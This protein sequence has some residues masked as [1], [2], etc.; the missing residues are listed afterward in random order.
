LTVTE[1]YALTN[2]QV[3]L[4]ASGLREWASGTWAMQAAVEL[5]LAHDVWC[6]RPDFIRACMTN[7]WVREHEGDRNPPDVVEWLKRADVHVSQSTPIQIEW[8]NM[9][10]CCDLLSASTSER[11]IL[12]VAWAFAIGSL[13]NMCDLSSNNLKHILTSMKIAGG[14]RWSAPTA[15]MKAVVCSTKEAGAALH[16]IADA[17]ELTNNHFD[18]AVCLRALADTLEFD[19]G[20]IDT[21]VCLR[22]IA[23]GL[24]LTGEA[25]GAYAS[26]LVCIA[27]ALPI[28]PVSCGR[29]P[30][31]VAW[32]N[33]DTVNTAAVWLK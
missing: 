29:A 1:P 13:S 5:L 19:G 31:A 24:A 26:C 33:P 30:Q 11:I 20:H 23:E 21:A 28:I 9:L 27:N 12:T 4:L 8:E 17:L 10:D 16:V 6:R 14:S 2:T 32:V 25:G 18:T 3:E 22:A 15:T 7:Q